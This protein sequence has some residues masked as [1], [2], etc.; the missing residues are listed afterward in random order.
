[1]AE[2]KKICHRPC[3]RVRYYLEQFIMIRLKK[4]LSVMQSPITRNLINQKITIQFVAF[5]SQRSLKFSSADLSVLSLMS[6]F[7]S[8]VGFTS[9]YLR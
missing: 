5:L 8:C 7:V 3:R 4:G 6:L 9:L 1:M 2:V